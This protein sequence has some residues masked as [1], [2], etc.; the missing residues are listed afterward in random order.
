VNYAY[1]AFGNRLSR[2][3]GSSIERFA[4]D[5]WDTALPAAAG[6]E[7]FHAVADLDSSNA[8]TSRR[9][10]GP[11]FDF[12]GARI[13]GNAQTSFY[14][15]DAQG[16]VRQ[17]TDATGAV[18]GSQSFD[19][20]GKLTSQSGTGLDRYG[21][22]GREWDAVAGLQYSRARMYD[23]GVGR[24]LTTDPLS[25]A[26]GDANLYRY[27]GNGP[28]NGT[29]PSGLVERQSIEADGD[30]AFLR[31]SEDSGPIEA[32]G[33][34]SFYRGSEFSGPIEADGDRTFFRGGLRPIEQKPRGRFDKSRN[35]LL[36]LKPHVTRP[37]D[38]SE[39]EHP[40]GI[41]GMG[42]GEQLIQSGEKP[43]HPT[44]QPD[45]KAYPPVAGHRWE[46]DG[47]RHVPG[48]GFLTVPSFKLI[49]LPG[50]LPPPNTG[51]GGNGPYGGGMGQGTWTAPPHQPI[52]GSPYQSGL[53][54]PV[55]Q[56]PRRGENTP[57][58]NFGPW[59]PWVDNS[60][61]AV[62]RRQQFDLMV[63]G[64]GLMIGGAILYLVPDCTITKVG[65]TLSLVKGWDLYRQG[66][67]GY[68]T[69]KPTLSLG[70]EIGV[71]VAKACG[72]DSKAAMEIGA[73]FDALFELVELGCAGLSIGHS[74]HRLYPAIRHSIVSFLNKRANA[75]WYNSDGSVRWPLNNGFLDAP[76]KHQL[77]PGEIVDR[78]GGKGGTFVSP[79]NTPF[80]QRSLPPNSESRPYRRCEILKPIDVEMG[81]VAPWFDQP[82]GGIQYKLPKS[83]TE[84]ISEGYIREIK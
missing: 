78:Y 61:E 70:Q 54:I 21:Y 38:E 22:T 62:F 24:W 83:I 46:F 5:G 23:P 63:E 45:P 13:D 73:K 37:G 30:R 39:S 18:T 28:T 20:F 6:T 76:Q 44:P 26:A 2:T 75:K 29:D 64:I 60:P 65:G 56:L 15:G 36:E 66:W 4:Y 40:H 42:R 34:R 53:G 1:D 43:S 47:Y 59:T 32:D 81:I 12:L 41:E 82:G 11:G 7:N 14:L 57:P 48:M 51:F 19:A 58:Q 80:P 52:L 77:K 17:V 67:F 25:F 9:L 27:V 74:I 3:Q 50:T 16:S 79:D 55:D 68:H 33:G 84:L 8:V 69:G 71:F 10:F 72:L 31:G 49:P 35:G